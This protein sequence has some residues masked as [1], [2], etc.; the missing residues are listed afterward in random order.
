MAV[1]SLPL[2]DAVEAPPDAPVKSV[3]QLLRERH[4]GQAWAY[5]E[6]VRNGTGFQRRTRT[7]DAL[8]MSLFPS[9]GLHLHGFEVK[10]SRA[11]WVKERDTPEKAEEIARFC[12]YWW[13]VIGDAKIVPDLG[14][15]PQPWGLLVSNGRRLTVKKQPAFNK[16]ALAPTHAF[17]GAILRK[18]AE[19]AGA[20]VLEEKERNEARNAGWREGVAHAERYSTDK[21]TKE[22]LEHLQEAVDAFEKAS[23]VSI[24]SKWDAGNIGPAVRL[25]AKGWDSPLAMIERFTRDA[26]DLAAAAE[27]SMAEINAAMKGATS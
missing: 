27:K 11:D 15:V 21:R 25:L 6:E 10:V 20:S 17:L 24:R 18:F 16:D 2:L 22:Q 9:R 14:E 23:G 26:R 12:H 8:A 13:L 19:S 1:E 3:F 7:A 5:F 4:A